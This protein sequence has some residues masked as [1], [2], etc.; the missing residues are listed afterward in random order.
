MFLKKKYHLK[1]YKFPS[2][3]IPFVH[4]LDIFIKIQFFY[5]RLPYF[6]RGKNPNVQSTVLFWFWIDVQ[7]NASCCIADHGVC[8]SLDDYY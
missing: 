1:K 8:L 7:P 4:L 5:R 3:E 2:T 6:R